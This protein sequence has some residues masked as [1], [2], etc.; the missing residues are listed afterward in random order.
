MK[1]LKDSIV[2]PDKDSTN[3]INCK[4]CY[5]PNDFLLGLTPPELYCGLDGGRPLSGD[6]MSEPFNYYDQEIYEYQYEKWDEW[7]EAHK[8]G[9]TNYCESF[10]RA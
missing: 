10:E 9:L 2:N 7:A 1:D 6:I 5:I 8:V 3:C 4:H